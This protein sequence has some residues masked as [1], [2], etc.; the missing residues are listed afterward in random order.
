MAQAPKNLTLTQQKVTI[1]NKHGNKLVGILHESGTTEI[2]ILCHGLGASKEDNIIVNLAAGL[3]N[4]GISSFRFDFSGNGESEG[5]FE[6]GD[7][8]REV[9]DLHAVGQHF[10]EANRK[11]SAII[12]HSKGGD[13][14]LLYAS[15]YHDIK[16]VVN[17]S[18]RYDLKGGLE[19]RLGKDFMEKIRK[20]GFIDVKTNSGSV[21]YRVTEES[22]KERLSINMHEEC[23]QIDKE[24]RVFTVHGSSDTTIPV[25]D[26]YE[27]AKILPNHKL[28]IIEGA[29]H[30]Y[31]NHQADLT[32]VVVNY[33]KETLQLD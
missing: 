22:L 30:V 15:K 23:L 33:I 26:A 19:D 10:H 3:D 21:E 13:T 5:T 32:S 4:A 11:V 29:D 2:V 31:S 20:E 25:E 8:W 1:T 9:D 14:V 17:L 27:F 7:Y 16:T 6:F 18:G 12:G 28:H 24:C